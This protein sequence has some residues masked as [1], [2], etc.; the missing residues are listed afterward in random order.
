MTSVGSVISARAISSSLRWP[1]D[2]AP[3]Y[4][5][6]MW[7]SLNR[8]EQFIGPGLDLGLLRLPPC[9]GTGRSTTFSPFWPVAPSFMFSMHGQLGEALGEL[10]RAHHAACGHAV[11]ATP[12]IDAPSKLHW[13]VFGLVEAGDQVEEGRLAG[14][15]GADQGGDRAALHLE[16]LDVDGDDAT[17]RTADA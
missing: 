1:P 10:E 11:R 16:V 3:A 13:P 12:S 9:T 5:S 17:E 6:R 2:S 7:S 4:S 8:V 14:A 15:V